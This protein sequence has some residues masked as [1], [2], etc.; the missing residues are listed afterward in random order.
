VAFTADGSTV[1]LYRQGREVATAKQNGIRYPT[2]NKMLTV[3]AAQDVQSGSGANFCVWDGKLDE[4]AIF[5]DALSAE[6]IRKLA[7]AAPR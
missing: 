4:I 7:G 1:R 6:D 5:N 3:G 2:Q